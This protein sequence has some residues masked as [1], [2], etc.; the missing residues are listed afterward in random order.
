MNLPLFPLN[1]VAFPG[2][3]LNLHIFE[4][5]YRQL[6]NEC[7]ETGGTFG[8]PPFLDGK[9]STHGTEIRITELSQRYEDGRLDIKS[10]GV[11]VFI[12]DKFINPIPGK[13]YSGGEITWL[14]NE[15]YEEVMPGLMERLKRLF[16]LLQLPLPIEPDG[17]CISFRVGHKV[18]LSTDEE[19]A[20]LQITRETDRQ[21]FLIQHLERVLPIV[22]EL[23]RSKDRIRQNG[24]FKNL[25]PLTF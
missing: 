1:L 11:R 4:P 22:A 14:E 13:L 12:L 9:L 5:R 7:L 17:G 20:L 2:E 25:D 24:H 15:P 3:K 23:E 18:G 16:G 8:V 19:Y 6:I 10:V 21:A